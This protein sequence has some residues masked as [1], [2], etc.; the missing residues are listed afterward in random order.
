MPW[1]YDDTGIHAQILKREAYITAA[2]M[3]FA[4]LWAR[5]TLGMRTRSLTPL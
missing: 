2:S 5:L 4:L 1:D 3:Q